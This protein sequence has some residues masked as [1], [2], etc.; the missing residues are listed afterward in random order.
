MAPHP[1]PEIDP[2]VRMENALRRLAS[3]LA[4]I[5]SRISIMHDEHQRSATQMHRLGV[6]QEAS[7]LAA[8]RHERTLE[9]LSNEMAALRRAL[10]R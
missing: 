2:L 10:E 6:N 7:K 5:E 4:T 3:T 1:R 9:T 8:R